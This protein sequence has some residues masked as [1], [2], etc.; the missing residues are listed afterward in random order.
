MFFLIERQ[1]NF[2]EFSKSKIA[3]TNTNTIKEFWKVFFFNAKKFVSQSELCCVYRKDIQTHFAC[4]ANQSIDS[5]DH[6]F[7]SSHLYAHAN[8]AEK[9]TF[10]VFPNT[11]KTSNMQMNTNFVS[12]RHHNTETLTD[13]HSVVENARY[14]KSN[15]GIYNKLLTAKRTAPHRNI[16]KNR[17]AFNLDKEYLLYRKFEEKN[18]HDFPVKL[19]YLCEKCALKKRV[20]QSAMNIY[21]VFIF[22]LIFS[23]FLSAFMIFFI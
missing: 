5:F 2:I 3:Y 7:D 23:F 17:M 4:L 10:I 16:S 22:I 8:C 20:I 9:Y 11:Y 1:I 6:R 14:K 19:N 12:Q 15:F 13:V 21:L 18:V